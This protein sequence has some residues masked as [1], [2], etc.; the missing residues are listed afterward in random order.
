MEKKVHSFISQ[1]ATHCIY[2]AMFVAVIFWILFSDYKKDGIGK[3]MREKANEYFPIIIAGGIAAVLLIAF[4]MTSVGI[5][6][7]KKINK[8]YETA[9]QGEA[10]LMWDSFDLYYGV[11]IP[12]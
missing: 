5:Y 9:Q 1:F 4:V 8:A 10:Y 12:Q 3:M 6:N 2:A 7:A 11:E